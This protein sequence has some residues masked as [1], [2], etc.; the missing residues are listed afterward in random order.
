MRWTVND[1]NKPVKKFPNYGDHKIA[2]HFCFFPK[3]QYDPETKT[4]TYYWLETVYITYEWTEGYEYI[5][6][7]WGVHGYQKDYWKQIDISTNTMD[8]LDKI[9]RR[10]KK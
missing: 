1:K 6:D 8:A 3:S 2:E 10:N 9:K 4:T 5:Y 7:E